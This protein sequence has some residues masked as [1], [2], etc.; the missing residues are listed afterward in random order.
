MTPR[1]FVLS[2]IIAVGAVVVLSTPRSY[3]DGPAPE[4]WTAPYKEAMVANP[5]PR[6][7]S[8]FKMGKAV[9]TANCVACH[10]EAGKGDGLLAANLPIKPANLN[11]VEVWQQ[12]DG[13]LFWK[14]SHGKQPMPVW[15]Q[16]LS[17]EERWQVINYMRTTFAPA[18]VTPIIPK[19]QPA[20]DQGTVS[21]SEFEALKQQFTELQGRV[22]YT[23]PGS[24]KFFF[25]G[26]GFVNYSA[27][28][29][30]TNTFN[31]GISPLILFKPTDF[32]LIETSF[33][34]NL[35]TNPDTSSAT[36]IDL[37]I[38]E[39]SFFITDWLTVSAGVFPTPFGVYHNHFDP[40]WI[41]KFADDPLPWGANSITPGSTM[42]ID[43]RGAELIGDSKIVYDAYVING[44]N[45]VTTDP[46][47]A[48]S[49]AFDNWNDLKDEKAVGAR[50]GFIPIPNM[51]MGYSIL[52][53][54]VNPTGQFVGT[55]AVLQ[56]VDMNFRPDVAALHGTFDFRT[57]WVW[58]SVDTRTYDPTGSIGFGPLTY[59][60]Y[61]QGGVV[62]LCYRPTHASG[63][64]RNFEFCTRWDFLK[65]PELAPGGGTEQ[66]YTVGMC[67][68]FTPQT[69]LQV[70]YE[71]DRRTTS[72]GPAQSGLLVQLGFGL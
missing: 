69:V 48:G 33:D 7:K 50:L 32:L 19:E 56:A 47:A 25:A 35:N 1:H 71:F 44:P 23:F 64:V 63:I 13:A 60:N 9:F 16:S 68:W 54:K 37:T 36:S 3:G 18:G 39:A 42:G 38:A 24:E 65:I 43:F 40:P 22:S 4:K 41:T 49:L 52:Y 28:K 27:L 17:E 61:R 58:S 34:L 11:A 14:I 6:T 26:D 29:G 8:G 10:G 66:R 46:T 53:G 72:L 30:N 45:L 20:T 67:Y 59:T 2:S 70:D 5:F 51:E 57:E 12:T 55:H 21:R 31:A 15:S 62:Q